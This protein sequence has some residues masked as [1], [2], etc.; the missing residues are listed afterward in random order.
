M[1]PNSITENFQYFGHFVVVVCFVRKVRGVMANYI[2]LQSSKSTVQEASRINMET[3]D[4]LAFT[5]FVV[6]FVGDMLI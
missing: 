5:C 1:K 2:H 3:V 4:F 6:W